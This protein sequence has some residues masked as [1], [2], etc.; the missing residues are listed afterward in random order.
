MKWAY[1]EIDVQGHDTALLLLDATTDAVTVAFV[2]LICS[3]AL[4]VAYY[5]ILHRSITQFLNI[6]GLKTYISI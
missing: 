3:H 5:F 2:S 1:A 6:N 4:P